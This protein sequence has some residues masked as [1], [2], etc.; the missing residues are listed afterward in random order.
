MKESNVK[1]KVVNKRFVLLLLKVWEYLIKV[2]VD[3][4]CG[5]KDILLMK[6]HMHGHF[7]AESRGGQ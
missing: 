6:N 3:D 1:L 2:R 5:R 7:P 4:K